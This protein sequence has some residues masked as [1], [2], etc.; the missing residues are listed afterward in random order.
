M[1]ETEFHPDF[2]L[3]FP[4]IAITR[5][6]CADPACSEG[7]WRISLGWFVGSIHLY[8]NDGPCGTQ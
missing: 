7:H 2:F 3:L 6:E 4:C 8:F 1:I 5:G